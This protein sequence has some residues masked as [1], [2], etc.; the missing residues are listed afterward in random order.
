VEFSLPPL[1]KRKIEIEPL[2]RLFLRQFCHASGLPVPELTPEALRAMQSYSW[3]GNVR[4]LKNVMER[5]PLLS[6]GA[7]ITAEHV[8]T[9]TIEP[10]ELFPPE[11]QETTETFFPSRSGR[12]FEPAAVPSGMGLRF[13]D[14]AA[15]RAR[16]SQAL[17]QCA[18]N[19][20]RAA[21]LLGISRRTLINHLERLNMPRPK[22]P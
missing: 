13:K 21:R 20:T 8:P 2:A 4:E 16:L 15:D 12:S 7:P 9:D 14:D 19:Q 10:G 5:A 17:E 18:G 11:E 1:R 22:K 6:D 3:P